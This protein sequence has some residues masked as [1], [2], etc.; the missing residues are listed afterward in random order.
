[1][2]SSLL[3]VN[4][5]CFFSSLSVKTERLCVVDKT[6]SWSTVYNPNN[7][8]IHQ[9]TRQQMNLWWKIFSW[10]SFHCCFI[11]NAARRFRQS[12]RLQFVFVSLTSKTPKYSQQQSLTVELQPGASSFLFFKADSFVMDWQIHQ[13]SMIHSDLLVCRLYS[14]W[15]QLQKMFR[16][17]QY[18]TFQEQ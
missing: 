16:S 17:L 4:I 15:L 3:N 10:C 1:M 13:V 7:W 6:R 2:F 12:W 11:K 14:F 9:E 8:S 18:F 5:S